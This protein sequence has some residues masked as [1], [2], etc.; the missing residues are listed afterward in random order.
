MP[1][2][3]IVLVIL[4]LGTCAITTQAQTPLQDSSITITGRVQSQGKPIPEALVTLWQQGAGDDP[5]EQN[6]IAASHTDTAGN[7][8]L[9]N[10]LPGNYYIGVLAAGYVTGKENYWL[11]KLRFVTVAGGKPLSPFNFEMVREG[12][13]SGTVT[14]AT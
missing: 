8:E 5:S 11:E 14:D 2:F 10:V 1:R 9:K 13:I 12:V 3:V 4:F 7:Y 6:T